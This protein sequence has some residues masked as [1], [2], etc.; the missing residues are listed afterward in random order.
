MISYK[1]SMYG[2]TLSKPYEFLKKVFPQ[3]EGQPAF[4]DGSSVIVT[5]ESPQSPQDLGPMISVEEFD[6]NSNTLLK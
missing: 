5:F 3:W 1:C 6:I 2:A 4:S